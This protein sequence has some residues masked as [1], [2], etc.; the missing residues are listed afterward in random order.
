MHVGELAILSAEVIYVHKRSVDVRVIVKAENMMTGVQKTTNRAYMTYVMP[1][2]D[3]APPLAL[4]TTVSDEE[5]SAIIS[6]YEDRKTERQGRHA[7]SEQVP[8]KG[9]VS[10]LTQFVGITD[11][12]DNKHCSGGTV[13]KLIDNVAGLAAYRHTHTNVVTANIERLVFWEPAYLGDLIRVQ[14]RINFTS[15]RSMEVEV[16]VTKELLKT[17]EVKVCCVC[18]LTFVSLG[19]DGRIQP[20][21]QLGVDDLDD[22]AKARYVAGQERYLRKKAARAHRR[23]QKAA[24]LKT[25]NN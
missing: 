7:F 13:M 4:P 17:H 23:A 25:K 6:R 3:P 10:E 21:A 12:V 5:A 19:A 11:C 15:S 24:Q 2:T 16:V 22:V 1:G 9:N 18:R 20:I 14:G 8:L